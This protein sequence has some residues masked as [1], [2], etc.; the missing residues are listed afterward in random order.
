MHLVPAHH[1]RAARLVGVHGGHDDDHDVARQP[2]PAEQPVPERRD[3]PGD[4]ARRVR[5]PLSG[6]HHRHELRERGRQLDDVD[7]VDVHEHEHEHVEHEQHVVEQQHLLDDVDDHQHEH[8]VV[9]QHELLD[10]EHQHI[11]E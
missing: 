4:R 6:G 5:L 1:Q 11:D 2:V 10:H 7:H 8:V 9:D 3:V